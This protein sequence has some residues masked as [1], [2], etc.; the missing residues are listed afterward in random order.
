MFKKE[1]QKKTTKHTF[2]LRSERG[3]VL[4]VSYVVA[5]L[6]FV[7]GSSYAIQSFWEQK[8]ALRER[9]R[10][11]TVY[12]SEGGLNYAKQIFFTAFSAA[13]NGQALNFS[14]FDDWCTS[15]TDT[16]G[17]G[18]IDENDQCN[19]PAS[20]NLPTLNRLQVDSVFPDGIFSIQVLSTDTT[21]LDYA[22]VKVRICAKANGNSATDPCSADADAARRV[23]TG[24]LRFNLGQSPVFKYGYFINNFGYMWGNALRS[25]GDMR[26]NGDF[27]LQFQPRIDGDVIAAANSETGATGKIIDQNNALCI[28]ASCIN[29]D[30]VATYRSDLY[31]ALAAR[32]SDPSAS[33]GTGTQYKVEGGYRGT[34]LLQS[35]QE[36]L[37]MP[38]L[39]NISFYQSYATVKQGTLAYQNT[40]GQAT[41]VSGS[42]S[43]DLILVGTA[44]NPIVI[45]GPI[46]ATGDVVIKGTVSGKGTIYAGRNVHIIGNLT[47]ANGPQWHKPDT[48]PDATTT[49]N[50]P[51]D[52]LGLAAKGNVI[53]GNYT[54]ATTQTYL[55]LLLSPT[56]GWSV[57]HKYTID[58]SDSSLGY[59]NCTGSCIPSGGSASSQWFDG[60]YTAADG[61][62]RSDGTARK[63][64]ES[65][66]TSAQFTALSPTNSIARIDAVAYTNHAYAGVMFG[67]QPQINGSMISRDDGMVVSGG[68]SINEDLR[69]KNATMQNDYFYLPRTV[70]FPATRYWEES[71]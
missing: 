12:T 11:R 2:S 57:T 10:I 39:G 43:G 61:T 65:N 29:Y 52:F 3:S 46:V 23:I 20:A 60:D 22:D 17:N 34:S 53:V 28:S 16:N 70:L 8:N 42:Y 69:V 41:S 40:S 1:K 59:N 15:K 37:A 68:F 4:I 48:T 9:D 27:S 67:S 63:F 44:A 51:K 38:Y 58:A 50:G 31:T 24:V 62:A 33:G 35:Q 56:G 18:L 36:M 64:Y 14:W 47:Y 49:A 66:L 19:V 54:D 45:N 25:N 30:D 71:S 55:N 13:T 32:P 5:N 21:H 7:L 6:L 26:A